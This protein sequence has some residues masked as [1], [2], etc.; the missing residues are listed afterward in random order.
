MKQLSALKLRHAVLAVFLAFGLAACSDSPASLLVKAKESIAKN[1][2]KAAE[3]HLKNL[4]QTEDNAEA[5]YLLG[6]V[7]LK[8]GDLRGAEKEFQ[9]A[10][11]GGYD[12]VKVAPEFASVLVQLGNFK[13]VVDDFG[14]MVPENP[15]R[16]GDA[17][18]RRRSCASR[19]GQ[20][21][22]REGELR[23]RA[24]RESRTTRPHRSR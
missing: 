14:T 21:R 6:T 15:E 1:E 17:A 24:R 16:Q 3:I 23:V 2:G 19:D 20:A 10:I 9:R 13:K 12:K 22:R 18:D 11:D 4:L 7:Y 8:A 5:R